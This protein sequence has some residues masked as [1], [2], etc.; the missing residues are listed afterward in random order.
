[1]LSIRYLTPAD[2]DF[3]WEMVYQAIFVPPGKEPPPRAVLDRPEIARYARDWGRVDD[4]GFAA[5]EDLT[6]RPVGA[7]WCRRLAGED[8]GYG[9]IDDRVPELS[10]AV[11]PEH[12]GLGIGTRLMTRLLEL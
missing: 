1:M 2:Q 12:C 9:W 10:I 4:I 8:R 3:L 11:R 6:H 7:A 5:V